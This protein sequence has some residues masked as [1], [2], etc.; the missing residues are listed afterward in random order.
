MSSVNFPFL[1]YIQDLE[2]RNQPENVNE[3][4]QKQ[5]YPK[6]QKKGSLAR[7]KN[8]Q[9]IT[10]LL[11]ENTTKNCGPTHTHTSK[12]SVESLDFHLHKAVTSAQTHP[13]DWKASKKAKQGVETFILN[14]GQR[15]WRPQE[16]Q[17]IGHSF[18][19]RLHSCQQRLGEELK[20]L[21]P[22]STNEDHPTCQ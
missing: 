21:S 1:S 17:L 10:V 5:I 19:P 7:Q 22:F 13:Q 8:S 9:I 4:R 2:I 20:L 16:E 14:R 6:H 12:G 3:H 18:T 15:Q 11:Q